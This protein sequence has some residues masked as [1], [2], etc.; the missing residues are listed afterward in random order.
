ME[1]TAEDRQY[2]NN[3]IDGIIHQVPEY[4]NLINSIREEWDVHNL[5]DCVFGMVFQTF[6]AKST[7]Y[8]KDKMIDNSE[9]MTIENIVKT[10][11]LSTEIFSERVPEIKQHIALSHTPESER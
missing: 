5:D 4:L 1:F 2:L 8:F 6:V 9:E 10:G 7:E 3:L 11:D